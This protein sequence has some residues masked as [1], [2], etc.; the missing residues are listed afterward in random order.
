MKKLIILITIVAWT[1]LAS[2]QNGVRLNAGDRLFPGLTQVLTDAQRESLRAAL[3][4]QYGQMQP[5]AEQMRVSRQALLS[6]ITDGSFNEAS[7]RQDAQAA[8][9]AEAE[10]TVIYARALSQ[11]SP[12]L[13][14]AQIQQVRNFQPSQFQR[15]A[16]ANDAGQSVPP[17]P[18]LPM[19][20]E[21]PRDSNGLPVVN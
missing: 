18:Q 17:A 12:P 6:E 11:M 16:G 15:G 3:K 8:A 4:L 21:M 2:A 13:S 9:N 14:A 1:I 19:P 7:A 10:L 5:L 20:P